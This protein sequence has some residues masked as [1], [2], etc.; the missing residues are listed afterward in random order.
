D[1]RALPS[2]PCTAVH[3]SSR[4]PANFRRIPTPTTAPD[5]AC[6]LLFGRCPP[7]RANRMSSPLRRLVCCALAGAALLATSVAAAGE[8]GTIVLGDGTSIAGEIIEIVQGDH[9]A[10]RLPNGEIRTVQW[11]QIASMQVGA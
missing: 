7:K 11:A 9:L 10:L 5:V 3:V 1:G 4:N 2:R 6:L 8:N